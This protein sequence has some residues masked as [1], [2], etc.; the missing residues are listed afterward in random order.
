MSTIYDKL[1]RRKKICEFGPP[2]THFFYNFIVDFITD[3]CTFDVRKF[4]EKVLHISEKE[5]LLTYIE[6]NYN[7]DAVK[8]IRNLLLINQQV[9]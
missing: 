3:E 4:K 2:F 6:A 7:K 1:V 5:D 8:L 9:K